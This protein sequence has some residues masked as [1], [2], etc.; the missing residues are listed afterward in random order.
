MGA[1]AY[2]NHNVH[3]QPLIL[4]AVPP[5]CGT[6]LEIGCGDGMLVRKLAERCAHVTGIDVDAGMI[7]L[8]REHTNNTCV[9]FVQGDFI[10]YPEAATGHFDF[11][12]ANT[13]LHHMDF[14]RALDNIARLLRPGGR[15]TVVGLARDASAGDYLAAAVAVPVDWYHKAVHREG[16]SGAP[17]RD[18]DMSWDEVKKP[19][20]L[21]CPASGTAA[22]CS[23]AIPCAGTS[24]RWDGRA[25]GRNCNQL[26]S[27]GVLAL[28]GGVTRR[29]RLGFR[30]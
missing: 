5:G 30:R 11:I 20:V 13:S 14:E 9:S 26:T 7:A 28:K 12:C 19:P 21:P 27:V 6:A 18:P 10:G 17:I 24:Q 23:G 1:P 15:A 2:W 3:Y 16:S 4:R 29:R 8:A 22:I 25:T